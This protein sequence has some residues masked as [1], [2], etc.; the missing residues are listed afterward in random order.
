M[1]ERIA[2]FVAAGLFALAAGVQV[3]SGRGLGL[4][5]LFLLVPAL[6]FIWLAIGERSTRR[7]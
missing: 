7:G 5:G 3:A 4:A 6:L 1:T 2:Y